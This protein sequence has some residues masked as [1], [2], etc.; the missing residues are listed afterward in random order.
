[1]LILPSNTKSADSRAGGE[2]GLFDND[3]SRPWVPA[4]AGMSRVSGIYGLRNS[5]TCDVLRP[6]LVKEL[7]LIFEEF[8]AERSM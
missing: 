4:V 2:S 6:Q 5:R 7:F 3:R 1:M 8:D